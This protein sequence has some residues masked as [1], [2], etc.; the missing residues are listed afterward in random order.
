MSVGQDVYAFIC[1]GQMTE[2]ALDR[3]GR[4]KSK[5]LGLENERI[6]A[7]LSI[8]TLDDQKVDDARAMAVVYAA[9]AAFENSV[10]E[11]I[12]KT[13]LEIHGED[14]W[15]DRVKKEVREGAKGRMEREEKVRWHAQRGDDPINYTMLPDLMGIIIKNQED[16]APFIH[17]FRW[18]TSIFDAIERSRNVIMHSGTLDLR[19]IARLGTYIRDWTTQVAT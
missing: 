3:A 1:R 5:G 10:R 18:A 2:E 4:S 15:T 9:I 19:D 17:D 7:L 8:A 6:E 16:F 14:W 12:S 11:M 13:L